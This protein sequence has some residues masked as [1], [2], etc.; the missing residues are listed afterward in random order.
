MIKKLCFAA[1]AVLSKCHE[2][3]APP[4]RVV[5][6]PVVI[7]AGQ[8]VP[9]ERQDLVRGAQETAAG[10]M[11]NLEAQFAC[12]VVCLDTLHRGDFTAI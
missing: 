1:V 6:A 7:V 9:L 4:S 12:D 10:A 8:A 11:E 3:D 2:G 5:K